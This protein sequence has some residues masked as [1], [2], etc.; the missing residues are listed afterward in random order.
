MY[1]LIDFMVFVLLIVIFLAL[2]VCAV[3]FAN[4]LLKAS[5][6]RRYQKIMR[7]IY[8]PM[9][10]DKNVREFIEG[11]EREGARVLTLAYLCFNGKEGTNEVEEIFVDLAESIS[12]AVEVGTSEYVESVLRTLED[13]GLH[14][15]FNRKNEFQYSMKY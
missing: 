12:Y 5:S 15:R 8:F 9:I 2:A 11:Y 1:F 7:E 3:Y 13:R 6:E 4:R 10:K 14:V